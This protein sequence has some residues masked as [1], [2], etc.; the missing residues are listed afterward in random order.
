VPSFPIIDTHLHV[1]D[2]RHL[3]YPWL[4]SLPLLNKPYLLKDFDRHCGNIAVAQMVFVQCEADFAQFVGE[5]A[6]VEQLAASEDPRL[7][8]IVPWA[9]LEQGRK[10]A[11][12][13]Q[14][15][16]RVSRRVKGIRRIIQFEADP[17]FCLQTDFVEGV[18]L[19]GD[20]DLHFELCV[21]GGVQFENA[22]LLV[23][24]CPGVRFILDHIGKPS[25][26]EGVLEP[27]SS[28]IG[29]LA[30][31]PNVWCKISGLVTEA[32]F[33]RWQAN[34][35]APY[36]RRVLDV[37]GVNRVMYGGDWPVAFQASTYTRWVE[38]LDELLAEYGMSYAETQK[39]YRDNATAFYR[40]P[41]LKDNIS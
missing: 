20:F 35:L 10:A 39:V 4:S 40:L 21:K 13:I 6:W 27:W 17:A 8:A 31:L 26:G 36:V 33:D 22:R 14:T 28:Q 30:A 15:L 18:R 41:E 1:W 34:D 25:I 5:A 29:K 9:P 11:D 16:L 3:D 12:A 24:Q 2:P 23:E 32:D 38:T 19:L 7:A 37:F